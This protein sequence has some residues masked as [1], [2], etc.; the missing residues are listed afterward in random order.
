MRSAKSSTFASPTLVTT[1][2]AASPACCAGEPAC[3]APICAPLPPAEAPPD[4]LTLPVTPST[5]LVAVPFCMISW[6]T[7]VAWSIGIAKPRPML[8]PWPWV[9][10]AVAMAELMPTT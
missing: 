9:E 7:R 4:W 10:L 6:A 5:G 2:P 8:P 1:S 3:T